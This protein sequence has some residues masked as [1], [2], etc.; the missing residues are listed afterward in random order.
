MDKNVIGLMKKELGRTI[1]KELAGLREKTYRYLIY[2]N[3]RDK[4]TKGTEK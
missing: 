3:N 1:M 2:N 4:K